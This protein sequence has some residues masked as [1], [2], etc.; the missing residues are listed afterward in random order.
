M[1]QPDKESQLC[2]QSLLQNRTM[3]PEDLL[4]GIFISLQQ[5]C[6]YRH[7]ELAVGEATQV[8]NA[9]RSLYPLYDFCTE[10]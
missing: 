3:I 1:S 7:I 6:V 4:C 9:T 10:Q 8:L 2:F 5:L